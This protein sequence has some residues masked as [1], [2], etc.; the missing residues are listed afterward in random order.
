LDLEKSKPK[1]CREQ[2]DEKLQSLTNKFVFWSLQ[3]HL[4]R[5]NKRFSTNAMQHSIEFT[6]N[7]TE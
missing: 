1:R 3:P 6:L 7:S 5:L 4:H 2:Q